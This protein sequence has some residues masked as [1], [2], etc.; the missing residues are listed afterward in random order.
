MEISMLR[1]TRL[2]RDCRHD[3]SA[4]VAGSEPLGTLKTAAS[5]ATSFGML[6]SMSGITFRSK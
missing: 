4:G 2:R 1:F 5:S 3:P 6:Q